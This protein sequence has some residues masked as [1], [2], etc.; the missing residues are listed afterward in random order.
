[1]MSWAAQ[2]EHVLAVRRMHRWASEIWSAH[3]TIDAVSP[4]ADR[5]STGW[6]DGVGAQGGPQ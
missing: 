2:R 3:S 5:W 1:M 4:S 6:D